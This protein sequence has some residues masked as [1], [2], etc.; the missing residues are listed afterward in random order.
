MLAFLE[1]LRSVEDLEEAGGRW[2]VSEGGVGVLRRNLILE[3]RKLDVLALGCFGGD[4]KKHGFVRCLFSFHTEGR[5][6]RARERER[7]RERERGERGQRERER[8]RG[9]GREGGR[10][11]GGERE[12]VGVWGRGRESEAER[13]RGGGGGRERE[14]RRNR[15]RGRA[16]N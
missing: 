8:E 13:E 9:G 15:V 12:R 14:M 7:E 3:N 4:Q 6:T 16:T 1:H 2:M 11:K 10:E 5:Q